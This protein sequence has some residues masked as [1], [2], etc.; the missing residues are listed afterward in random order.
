[1]PKSLKK[2]SE[3]KE[4]IIDY[5]F[6]PFTKWFDHLR[7]NALSLYLGLLKISLANLAAFILITL[8]YILLGASLVFLMGSESALTD[9]TKFIYL[10][11]ENLYLSA[12]L[13]LLTLVYWVLLAWIGSSISLSAYLF[14]DSQFRKK[15]FRIIKSAMRIKWGVLRYMLVQL[16]IWLAIV[17]P[18]LILLL[19][20]LAAGYSVF[21]NSF[22]GSD[23]SALSGLLIGGM[24]L[25]MLVLLAFVVYMGI[26]NVLFEIITQFW[27]YG[28]L[29][30][31][32]GII[33]SL[34]RSLSLIKMR[35]PEVLVFDFFFLV[36]FLA[37]SIPLTL[38][39]IFS[40]VFF[41]FFR[42]VDVMGDALYLG[43][44][45]IAVIFNVLITMLLATLVEAYYIPVHYLFWR[46]VNEEKISSKN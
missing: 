9:L 18:F 40:D 28:F 15:P 27:L 33:D 10:L 39:S 37:A 14:A 8:L 26:A 38:F 43:I 3:N 20:A 22:D 17:S 13:V 44:Y 36:G 12:L 5:V 30:E 19:L 31:G 46:K 35:L 11:F 42:F 32:R 25:S 45:I 1:M 23:P 41:E 21:G 24:F 16:G 34:K 6:E 2:K 4:G 29:L 7:N